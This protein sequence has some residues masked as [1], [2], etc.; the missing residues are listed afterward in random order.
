MSIHGKMRPPRDVHAPDVLVFTKLALTLSDPICPLHRSFDAASAAET[1]CRWGRMKQTGGA[2]EVNRW[3]L[4]Q[5]FSHSHE[6][7]R[8]VSTTTTYGPSSHMQCACLNMAMATAGGERG[9][10]AASCLQG[11]LCRLSDNC[12]SGHVASPV[13]IDRCKAASLPPA[14]LAPAGHQGGL[15]GCCYLANHL[16]SSSELLVSLDALHM[17]SGSTRSSR[18]CRA[19]MW[20]VHICQLPCP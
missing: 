18:L 9:P 6:S 10:H 5:M 11:T 17:C 3:S 16:K 2:G 14:R 1:W 15:P 7:S 4:L 8:L 12:V 13:Q 19:S 20:H